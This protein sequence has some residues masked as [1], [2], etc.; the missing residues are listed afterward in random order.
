MYAF[1]DNQQENEA[2]NVIKG[3]LF[4]FSFVSVKK[5]RS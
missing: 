3:K 1:K 4:I 5:K 2:S